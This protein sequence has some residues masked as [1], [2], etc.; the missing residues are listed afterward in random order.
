LAGV[1]GKAVQRTIPANGNLFRD[2]LPR[3]SSSDDIFEKW[4]KVAISDCSG[5]P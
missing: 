2:L 4:V 1:A 3:T 5:G